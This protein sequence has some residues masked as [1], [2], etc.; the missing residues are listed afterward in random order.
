M[1]VGNSEDDNEHDDDGGLR[2]RESTHVTPTTA[3]VAEPVGGVGRS[4]GGNVVEGIRVCGCDC[5]W[6][7]LVVCRRLRLPT[8]CCG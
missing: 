8:A 2:T 4:E 5:L 1:L 7:D 3:P 6:M